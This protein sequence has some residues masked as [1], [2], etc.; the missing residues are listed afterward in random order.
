MATVAGK[1]YGKY[2]IIEKLGAGGSGVVYKAYDHDFDRFVALKVLP[3]EYGTDRS[4]QQRFKQE[5]R[6][7]AMLEHLHILPVY[8]FGHEADEAYLVMRL[9]QSGSLQNWL[10]DSPFEFSAAVRILRGIAGALDY[11]HHEGVLHRDVKPANVL[12]DDDGNGFLA[13]FG[14]AR[15]LESN[16]HLTGDLIIGTP[17][18]LSPEHCN[19]SSIIDGRTDQYALGV[20]AYQMMTGHLPFDAPRPIQ[21]INM[22]INNQPPPPTNFNPDLPE[23]VEAVLLKVLSKDP[24]ERYENCTAFV[25]AF[26]KAAEGSG[27]RMNSSRSLPEDLRNRIDSALGGLQ[28]ED[29]E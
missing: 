5:A 22:Q 24:A 16:L 10:S 23:L 12:M 18:Y 15:I 2:I 26:E 4:F 29:D 11:A 19:G 28:A 3:A 9:M 1:K 25:D 7:I 21:I 14:I 20:M 17:A 6:A 8:D 13:D 27:L